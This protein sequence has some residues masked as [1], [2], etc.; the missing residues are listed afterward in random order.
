MGKKNGEDKRG[1]KLLFWN[2][3]GL[4]K[5]DN[6]FWDYVKNFDFVG[7]T[8]TWI[9]ER[10]W[11]K[12]KDVLPK[13]FQ[14]KLQGAKKEKRKGRAKGGIITGVKKDI[15]EIEEGAIEMEGIVER[16]LTVN[17]KRWR[18]YTIYSRRMRNTKQEIQEKIEES[19]E[20]VLLLEGD[21]NARIGNRSR[22]ED[23]ENTRK[24][25]DKVENKDGKL[26]WELIE[27]R[28][29]S[30][31]WGEGMGRGGGIYLDR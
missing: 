13:E 18:I 27:E 23:G 21:F 7:L 17:K 1:L 24:S 31:E 25:K 9:L 30:L 2:I 15:K 8:E 29:G 4:K 14:W 28:L 16:K 22:E 20:E 12:L 3:A 10:D 19:E 6:L 26:L 5:K 11:N